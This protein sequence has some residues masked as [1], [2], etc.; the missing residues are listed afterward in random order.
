MGDIMGDLGEGVG[1]IDDVGC[2]EDV[3]GGLVDDEDGLADADRPADGKVGLTDDEG[4]LPDDGGLAAVE[5]GLVDEGGMIDGE[6]GQLSSSSGWMNWILG[7]GGKCILAFLGRCG[8]S[9]PLSSSLSD[10]NGLYRWLCLEIK[11]N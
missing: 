1:L 10:S 6:G 7:R 4:S 2:L 8:V 11:T 9:C 5:G 3:D